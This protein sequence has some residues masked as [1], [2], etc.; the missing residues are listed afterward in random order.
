[1]KANLTIESDNNEYQFDFIVHKSESQNDQMIESE[2]Y[3]TWSPDH[4]MPELTHFEMELVSPNLEQHKYVKSIHIHTSLK[5][6]KKFICWTLPVT[7]KHT[8][9]SIIL[10]WSLGT[11]Y[12]METG[13]DFQTLYEKH[14]IEMLDFKSMISVLKFVYSFNAPEHP[15][16]LI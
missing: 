12:T 16:S 7:D 10:L 13:I 2:F 15:I 6:G 5:N 9:M 8:F 14:K 3:K 11:A 1:M 4:K